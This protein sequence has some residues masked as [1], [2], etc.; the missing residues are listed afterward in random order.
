MKVIPYQCNWEPIVSNWMNKAQYCACQYQANPEPQYFV[1]VKRIFRYHWGMG[2]YGITFN[3]NLEGT[4]QLVGH[5]DA[6]WAC[7]GNEHNQHQ[8]IVSC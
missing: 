7:D 4:I 3:G 5:C 2:N 1:A 6:D 8:D